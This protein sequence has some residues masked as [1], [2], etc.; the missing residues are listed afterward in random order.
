LRSHLSHLFKRKHN[1]LSAAD[2]QRFDA[3]DAENLRL[4]LFGFQDFGRDARGYAS[5]PMGA[6]KTA[7]CQ[8]VFD[9]NAG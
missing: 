6:A 4:R 9:P 7:G 5:E 3:G 1:G 2:A 8:R